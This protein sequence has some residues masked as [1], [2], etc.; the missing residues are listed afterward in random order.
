MSEQKQYTSEEFFR[1]GIVHPL[2]P[3]QKIIFALAMHATKDAPMSIKQIADRIGMGVSTAYLGCMRLR[4]QELIGY[5][6]DFTTEDECRSFR[7]YY[8]NEA[9]ERYYREEL[10]GPILFVSRTIQ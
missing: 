3:T 2:R 10:I 5:V 1:S 6:Q 9:G 8:L 4:E 7:L